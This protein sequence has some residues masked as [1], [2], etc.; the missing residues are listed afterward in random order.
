MKNTW[1][2]DK[3]YILSS[4]SILLF[5]FS[6]GWHF[7]GGNPAISVVYRLK[8]PLEFA[9]PVKGDENNEKEK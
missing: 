8:R 2:I 4:S 5:L 1:S 7:L 6:N 9:V 3:V